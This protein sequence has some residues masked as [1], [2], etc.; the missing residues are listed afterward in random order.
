MNSSLRVI[1]CEPAFVDDAIGKVILR[2]RFREFAI[3]ILE[4]L[5]PLGPTLAVKSGQQNQVLAVILVYPMTRNHSG[6]VT[7][8]P[9]TSAFGIYPFRECNFRAGVV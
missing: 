1:V 8:Y 3:Q 9:C 4:T 5:D 7:I 6:R 2:I